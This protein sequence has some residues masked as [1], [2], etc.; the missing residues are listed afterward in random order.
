MEFFTVA[1]FGHRYIDNSFVIDDKLYSCI[2]NIVAEHEFVEFIVGKNGEFDTLATSAVRRFMRRGL[3]QKCS[4]GLVL[5]YCTAEYRNNEKSFEE[6]YSSVEIS[7][8]ASIAHPKG[9]IKSRNFEMVDRANLIICYVNRSSGG[10]YTAVEYAKSRGVP[11]I[12]L[13]EEEN[14]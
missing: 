3:G 12:N 6:F 8:A 5:P 2:K 14:L 7:Y 13:A 1:F 10:A 9:A 11:I 4:L